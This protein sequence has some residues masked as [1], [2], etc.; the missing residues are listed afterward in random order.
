MTTAPAVVVDAQLDALDA[1]AAAIAVALAEAEA[2]RAERVAAVDAADAAWRDAR[3][4]KWEADRDTAGGREV[5]GPH[6]PQF[7]PESAG[8]A[9]ERAAR[10]RQAA[11]EVEA[12]FEAAQASRLAW[13]AGEARRS[14]LLMQ[15]ARLEQR[16][17]QLERDRERARRA[18]AVADTGDAL[19][20]IKRR[21][22]LAGGPASR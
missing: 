4:V 7:V 3:R 8:A 2:G 10:Q 6:G 14:A 13:S 17:A 20:A 12:R 16:R 18:A 15:Q 21:L 11:A 5:L 9:Q 19:R 1:E 22:G